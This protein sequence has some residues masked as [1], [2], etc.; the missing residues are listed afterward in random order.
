MTISEAQSLL[1]C[2]VCGSD[3]M[4]V[5]QTGLVA[6]LNSL[7][8]GPCKWHVRMKPWEVKALKHTSGLTRKEKFLAEQQAE[9]DRRIEEANET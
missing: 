3:V 2:P 1:S 7:R 4:K 6:C 8:F 5:H 9:I